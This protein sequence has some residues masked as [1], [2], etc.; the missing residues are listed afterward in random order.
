MSQEHDRGMAELRL[1]LQEL[2]AESRVTTL[3][4]QETDRQM[5]ETTL[6]MQETD[7]QMKETDRQMK[8]TDRQMKETD[9]QMQETDRRI[10]RVDG[11]LVNLWGRLVE[12]IVQPAALRLF[13]AWGV[14]VSISMERVIIERPGYQK[15]IDILLV[16]GDAVVVVEVKTTLT[17]GDVRNFAVFLKRFHEYMPVYRDKHVL[18]AVAY[19]HATQA[20]DRHAAK[21]GLF[22]IGLTGD[23]L[24]EIRNDPAFQPRCFDC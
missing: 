23:G 9:R 1:L 24:M 22:I 16:N 15:E 2:A 4:M 14:P 18:G 17:A 5:Q 7:R 12:A 10:N 3:K 20:A 11:K 6:E 19:L 13:N 8:E 21:Q